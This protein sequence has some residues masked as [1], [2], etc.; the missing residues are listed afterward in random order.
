MRGLMQHWGERRR[1]A[2]PVPNVA[3]ITAQ[4]T[5]RLFVVAAFALTLAACDKCSVPVW[6]HDTPAAPQ[7]CHDD[8]PAP[9]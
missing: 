8:A 5:L 1:I 2:W 3:R 4:H 7:S 6:R 9:Q